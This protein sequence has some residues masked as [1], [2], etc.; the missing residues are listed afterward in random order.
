MQCLPNWEWRDLGSRPSLLLPDWTVSVNAHNLLHLSF[1]IPKNKIIILKSFRIAFRSQLL[2]GGGG[3]GST[4]F[5]NCCGPGFLLLLCER[6][7]WGNLWRV[8]STVPGAWKSSGISSSNTIS[9]LFYSY[10]L[11]FSFSDRPMTWDFRASKSLFLT[12]P[13]PL[14]FSWMWDSASIRHSCK[15]PGRSRTF[16]YQLFYT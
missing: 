10:T 6:M 1:L 2:W 12:I 5:Y 8:L 13:P 11:H 15:F 16:V 3:K 4:Y 9:P 14:T 7:R